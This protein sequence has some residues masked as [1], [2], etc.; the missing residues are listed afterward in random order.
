MQDWERAL[1]KFIKTWE[2]RKEVR[3]FLVCGSYVTGNPTKRSD[4][5]LH[6]VLD[7]SVDWRERGNKVVDSYLIEYFANSPNQI[8]EY[9]KE[10]F[11]ENRMHSQTQF[12]SGRIIKDPE[13]LVTQLKKEAE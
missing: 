3:G 11:E 4:I 10:D 5:D 13:G 6:I 9:F 1:Q 8:R 7:I 12:A 2:N